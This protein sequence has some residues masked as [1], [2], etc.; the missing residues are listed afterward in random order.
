[1][2]DIFSTFLSSESSL[3]R[4]IYK[5]KITKQSNKIFLDNG[6]RLSKQGNVLKLPKLRINSFSPNNKN[7]SFDDLNLNKGTEILLVNAPSDEE[8]KIFENKYLNDIKAKK[9]IKEIKYNKISDKKLNEITMNNK[10]KAYKYNNNNKHKDHYSLDKGNRNK[11]EK[12]K[13]R[14]EYIE[15]YIESLIKKG[16]KKTDKF[17]EATKKVKENKF[18]LENSINPAKYIQKQILDDKFDLDDFRTAK[19][20]KKC[21]NWNQKFREANYKNIKINIMNNI[22]LNSMEAEPEATDTKFLIDQ[23][24]S[25]QKHLNKFNFSKNIYNRKKEETID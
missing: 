4:N 13:E 14:Q 7:K 21:F 1:M 5:N 2:S 15:H 9:G 25:D 24:L 23:M 19:I 20:Q 18:F 17:S 10:N 22:F 6:L 12:S 11:N 8:N 3:R 16:K